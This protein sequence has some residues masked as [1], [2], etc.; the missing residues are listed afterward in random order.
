MVDISKNLSSRK[1]L[2]EE[3]IPIRELSRDAAIE[4]SFKPTPDYIAR[5]KELK[6]IR[7]GR[8]FYDPKIKNLHPWLAR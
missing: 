1:S 8:D 6:I 2:I 3:W 4:M 7:E 5:C